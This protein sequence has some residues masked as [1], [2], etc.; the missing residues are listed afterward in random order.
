MTKPVYK[1]LLPPDA[2]ITVLRYTSL[3][4]LVWMLTRHELPL[5]RLV[6]FGDPFEGSAPE[7]VMQEQASQ[8]GISAQQQMSAV[9]SFYHHQMAGHFDEGA[10]YYELPDIFTKMAN[11]RKARVGST[12][13]SCWQCGPESEGMWR[14]Y[15]GEKEGVA[16]KTTFARLEKSIRDEEI[17]AGMV[18]YVNYKT[19]APFKEDWDYVLHKRE[20]FR[21]EQEMRLLKFDGELHAQLLGKQSVDVLGCLGT[22]WNMDDGVESILVSPYADPW[23][24]EAVRATV[25]HMGGGALTERVNWSEL[26]AKARF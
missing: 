11:I 8:G 16:L 4:G 5:I 23:Y 26:Q 6:L 2:N 20:G 25:G 24:L 1:N 21:H 18:R 3:A 12:Y 22:P 13:A 19:V 9:K 15:C 17:L 14:L 10:V 7:S